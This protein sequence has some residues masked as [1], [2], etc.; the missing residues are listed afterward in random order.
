MT[1]ALSHF[2]IVEDEQ[3]GLLD[4]VFIYNCNAIRKLDVL[5]STV[6]TSWEDIKLIPVR[7]IKNQSCWEKAALTRL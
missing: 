6:T 4:I 3:H 7:D 5:L 1:D 2:T